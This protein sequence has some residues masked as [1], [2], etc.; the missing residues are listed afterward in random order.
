MQNFSSV[1]DT[2][3]K[4]DASDKLFLTLIVKLAYL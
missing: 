3:A 1:N 2:G 4:L